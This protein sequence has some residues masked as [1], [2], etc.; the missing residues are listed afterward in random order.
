M[1]IFKEHT[2]LIVDDIVENLEILNHILHDKYRVKA[3]KSGQSALEVAQKTPHLDLILLDIMMPKMDGYEVIDHLKKNKKTANIP[4]IFVSAKGE[5]FDQ[6]KAFALGAVD[7]IIKPINPDLVRSRVAAHIAL[8]DKQQHLRALV[9]Q[10]VKKRIAQEEILLKQSRLAAMGEMM[11]VITHQWKQPLSVILAITA[12]LEFSVELEELTN[13]ELLKE[14]KNIDKSV[15][16][17]SQTM[18][19]FKDY[20]KVQKDKELFRVKHEVESI[21]FMLDPIFKKHNINIK[22]FID[23]E[24]FGYGVSGEFKQIVLNLLSNAKYALIQR[25]RKESFIPVIEIKGKTKN[26]IST[27]VI[28][29]NGGGIA[30]EIM[31]KIFKNYYTTKEEN[32]TGIGLAMSKMIIEDQMHGEIYAKNIKNGVSFILNFPSKQ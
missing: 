28:S 6:T 24:V 27:L 29:D 7:Y 10:E 5:T 4:V 20:F 25:E 8:H 13:E 32:G 15:E 9:N 11:S 1:K 2:V 12:S 23:E 3:V 31:D 22:V 14:L 16:F 18:G 21:I 30:D 19:D 26:N 17:M